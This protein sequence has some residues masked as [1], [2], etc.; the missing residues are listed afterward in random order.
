MD[1]LSPESTQPSDRHEPADI[2][3]RLLAVERA[4]SVAVV[5]G[6]AAEWA[7]AVL[8]ELLGAAAGWRRTRD[9]WHSVIDDILSADPALGAR[10]SHLLQRLR[11]LDAAISNLEQ[12]LRDLASERDETPAEL[13]AAEQVREAL[14]AWSTACRSLSGELDTWYGEAYYRDR[15]TGD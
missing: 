3:R 1:S 12:R 11:T 5:P 13:E 15:G 9:A 8:E 7:G 4:A 10:V 14:L 6:E 2:D